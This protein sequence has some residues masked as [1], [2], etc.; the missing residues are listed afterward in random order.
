VHDWRLQEEVLARH[1]ALY[2]CQILHGRTH[3]RGPYLLALRVADGLVNAQDQACGLSGAADC[4]QLHQARLPYEGLHVIPNAL[5]AVNVDAVPTG[6][7]C[8]L[9][10]ELVENVGRVQPGIVADLAWDN[11][12]RLGERKHDELLLASDRQSMLSDVS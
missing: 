12:Q 8:V 6:A 10:P 5:R 4:V 7:P 1:S 3:V 9:H 11:L 2:A